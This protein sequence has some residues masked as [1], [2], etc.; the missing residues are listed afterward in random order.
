LIR[1]SSPVFTRIH[2]A[3]AK[4]PVV[5]CHEHTLGANGSLGQHYTEPIQALVFGPDQDG[6]EVSELP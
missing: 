4:M 6:N 2:G 3:I 5:D 1:A